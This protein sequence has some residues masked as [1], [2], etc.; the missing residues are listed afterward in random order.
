MKAQRPTFRLMQLAVILR[1]HHLTG[2]DEEHRAALVVVH[3]A[4]VFQVSAIR[5]FQQYCINAV[6]LP[7]ESQRFCL[8]SVHHTDQRMARLHAEVVVI[9]LYGI[10]FH[11]LVHIQSVFTI[12]NIGISSGRPKESDDKRSPSSRGL[13]SLTKA[14][15][16]VRERCRRR[17]RRFSKFARVIVTDDEACGKK[18]APPMIAE[19]AS[20][21]FLGL[22]L[23]ERAFFP[24]SRLSARG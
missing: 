20:P 1:P 15:L 4:S 9:G 5:I 14:V 3:T 22:S 10:Y 8:A 6:Q 12:A 16:Q 24:A 21:R 2:S 23:A 7:P 19:G 17:R 11:Y 13:S 18:E